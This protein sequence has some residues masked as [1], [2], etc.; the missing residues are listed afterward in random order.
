MKND[1]RKMADDIMKEEATKRMMSST[2]AQKQE[3]PNKGSRATFNQ[4]LAQQSGEGVG[5]DGS[6]GEAFLS[7]I[8]A[9][10]G[11]LEAAVDDPDAASVFAGMRLSP[12]DKAFWQQANPEQRM[13]IL[14]AGA[15]GH[16]I[17][18]F[19]EVVRPM[20]DSQLM[21]QEMQP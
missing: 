8:T 19:E 14:E 2:D 21:Q 9:N 15:S 17:G 7:M 12:E 11:A 20:N 16:L 3:G 4:M 6:M 18:S 13:Q 1:Y 5:G 10:Y